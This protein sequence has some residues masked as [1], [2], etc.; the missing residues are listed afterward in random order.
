M[1]RFHPAFRHIH[2]ELAREE[3]HPEGANSHGYDILAPLTEDGH[4][5]AEVWREHRDACRV[6]RFRDD[7]ED[8][9]GKLRH[10][11]GRRWFL[12][13]DPDRDDDDETGHRFEDEQ[14]VPGEYVAIRETDGELHTFRVVAVRPLD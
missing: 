9:V 13:Y 5:D 10:G 11:P 2:L 1:T 14:F 4:L 8:Q 12:D 6:R 7:E 3:G